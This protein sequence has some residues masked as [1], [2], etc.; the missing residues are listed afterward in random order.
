MEEIG[1]PNLT[2]DQM[3]TLSEIAENTAREYI[4]SNVPQKRILEL[5]ITVET[6]G[7]KPV[8]IAVDIELTLSPLMKSSNTEELANNAACKAFEAVEN[9]LRELRCKSKT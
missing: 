7:S 3:R 8:A 9:Y 2:K 1:I 4:L 5:D 6:T